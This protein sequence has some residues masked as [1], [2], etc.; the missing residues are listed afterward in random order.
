MFVFLEFVVWS[1]F[2]FWCL[3]F[4][5]CYRQAGLVLFTCRQAGLVLVQASE[6]MAIHN[7]FDALRRVP[8]TLAAYS[9]SRRRYV[10]YWSRETPGGVWWSTLGMNPPL[11]MAGSRRSNSA[12]MAASPRGMTILS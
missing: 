7:L 9:S 1:L 2:E 12:R 10:R 4:G 3:F 6:L 11:R 5:A 8:Q